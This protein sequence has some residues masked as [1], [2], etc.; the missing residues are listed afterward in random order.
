MLKRLL[1]AILYLPFAVSV[2]LIVL[3]SGVYW[4]ITGKN[5]FFVIDWMKDKMQKL[6]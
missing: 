4:I 3:L 2:G 5:L 6:L 1:F